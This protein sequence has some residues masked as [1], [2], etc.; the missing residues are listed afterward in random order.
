MCTLLAFSNIFCY[1]EKNQHYIWE[2]KEEEGKE[3][4]E[5]EEEEE[6]VWVHLTTPFN[7]VTHQPI[8]TPLLNNEL[9][10]NPTPS[11][12]VM[13]SSPVAPPLLMR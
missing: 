4:E 1:H 8:A 10:C 13:M 7:R 5:E 12:E 9:T 6:G 11:N 3:E 2:G